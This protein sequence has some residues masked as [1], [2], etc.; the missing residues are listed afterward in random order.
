M[1]IIVG[2][3]VLLLSSFGATQIDPMIGRVTSLAGAAFNV[4][5]RNGG[6]GEAIPAV[7]LVE[8]LDASLTAAKRVGLM[9][10]C[11]RLNGRH[12]GPCVAAAAYTALF[13]PSGSDFLYVRFAHPVPH[14]KGG[15][16]WWEFQS[17]AAFEPLIPFN[18][19]EPPR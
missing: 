2:S 11:I 1:A 19:Q 5:W 14:D 10:R 3:T 9:G 15:D 16:G 13:I 7:D 12:S 8:L 18:P 6:E 17:L 4:A